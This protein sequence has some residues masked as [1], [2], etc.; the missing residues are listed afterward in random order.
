MVTKRRAPR[1]A[2][3]PPP[4]PAPLDAVSAALAGEDD[5]ASALDEGATREQAAAIAGLTSTQW[6]AVEEHARAGEARATALLDRLARVEAGTARKLASMV[7]A[8][9]AGK[10]PQAWRAAAWLLEKR[11]PDTLRIDAPRAPAAGLFTAA[12]VAGL[13]TA[14]GDLVREHVEDEAARRRLQAGVA[15]LTRGLRHADAATA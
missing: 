4:P 5:I 7:I 10:S 12:Q 9:A 2:P 3:P 1:R 8:Q 13:L 6:A 14:I 11:Y 15:D